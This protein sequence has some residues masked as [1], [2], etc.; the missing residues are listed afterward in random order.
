MKIK[1]NILIIIL[2]VAI[3][4]GS[5]IFVFNYNSASRIDDYYKYINGKKI[6]K[7]DIDKDKV[8]WSYVQDLQDD[9]DKETDE[10]TKKMIDDKN[11]TNMNIIYS[12]LNDERRNREGI[13]PLRKY[14]NMI[15][16]SYSIK[17][18]LYSIYDVDKELKIGLLIN[19]KISKDFKD[20]SKNIIYLYPINSDYGADIRF[21]S[22]SDYASY[23]ALI[24]KYRIRLLKLNGND[25]KTARN[26][27]NDTNKMLE[28]IASKSKK[29]SDFND[30]GT[31]YNIITKN[32]LKEIYSNID[33]D[34]YLNILNIGNVDSFSIVDKGNY[35]AFNSY[36]TND[37]LNVLKEYFKIKIITN[38]MEFLSDD[39]I[40]LINNLNN[41]I[42]GINKK[43]DMDEIKLD[44]IETIFDDKI[45]IAYSKEHFTKE[46]KEK[47][48]KLIDEVLKYYKKNL[49]TNSFLSDK[50]K[51]KAITKLDN[52]KIRIGYP[53]DGIIY[54]DKYVLHRNESLFNN[55]VRINN[56]IYNENIKLVGTDKDN[57]NW[58]FP[59]TSINAFYNPQD[60]SINFPAA[61]Y[62]VLDD[63][64]KEYEMLGSVGFII[65]HEVTHAFDNNGSM[66]DE[67]GEYNN[68][69]TEKDL[70]EFN[71]RK[72][73]IVDYYNEYKVL[74][75]N[76]DGEKTLGENIADLGAIKCITS[77]AEE[78]N[79]KG[80]DYKTMYKS[81]AN[82]FL[83][84]YIDSYTKMVMIMDTHSP[85][86]VRVNGTLS[87]TG[88]FYEVYNI[89]GFDKMDKDTDYKVSM[90]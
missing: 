19:P 28:D 72:E 9:I 70:D 36:L 1:K 30:L 89:N 5:F 75:I 20:S 86:E 60:N 68:W 37:N 44:I 54:S 59:L 29:T 74:G 77:I 43:I 69:W 78:K 39:Y 84:E 87:S 4:L 47:V 32:E 53:E 82:F 31:Y 76:V 40:E 71:K 45:S 26:I 12:L 63:N 62:K 18:L 85:N 17:S 11:N 48:E 83:N 51:E 34:S 14:L 38:Y 23:K 79:A 35:K 67:K 61:L 6:D 81:F 24:S 58:A 66:F 55:I 10:L 21:Y 88:K 50:T 57:G 15:D 3:I 41:E 33:I 16:N 56:Y 13:E 73:A 27:S 80:E 90:W 42:N 2:F 25:A 64:S 65:A 49:K 8:G 7:R 46:H 22:D 52:I